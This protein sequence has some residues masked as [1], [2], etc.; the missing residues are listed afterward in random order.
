MRFETQTS[1]TKLFD[2]QVNSRYL[3]LA[4]RAQN[5]FG[6]KPC[7]LATIGR[8]CVICGLRPSRRYHRM[9]FDK[10]VIPLVAASFA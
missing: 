5:E 8:I 4:A 10:L 6:N 2:K 9:G 1:L 7:I 3:Y